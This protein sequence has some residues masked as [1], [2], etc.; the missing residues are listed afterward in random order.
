ME[1]DA[2]LDMGSLAG[3]F[4]AEDVV[5]RYNLKP[6]LS[7]TSYP[8]C[9]GCLKS[10]AIL[11]LR[12]TFFDESS[13]RYDTFDIKAHIL[14]AT[15]VDLI[16]GRDSIKKFNLFSKVPSQL[17]VPQ[18]STTLTPVAKPRTG[19]VIHSLLA[20]LTVE[21][22]HILGGS[23]PD[24]DEIDHDKTDTFKPWLPSP[25]TTDVLSLIHVSGDK[26]LQRR[27]R[28]LCKEFKDIFSNELPAAPAKIPEFHLIVKDDEWKVARNRAPPRAQN[29]KKQA[30]LFTTIETLL[31][32]GMIRKST[33]PHY[34]QVLLVPKPDNT[35]RM[36]VD[37]RALNDCTP[38]AS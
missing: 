18:G 14:K 7:D 23:A 20:S 3:D 21:A 33:S 38:D 27:L 32:Q 16:I 17:E 12:V 19:P 6:V 25:S 36:C 26:D 35:F 30:A 31:R 5:V 37:Y 8:V 11:L 29:P 1:V 13:N 34:S 15:P 28:T 24:D 2:L 10:K 22:Q 9:S 4:I